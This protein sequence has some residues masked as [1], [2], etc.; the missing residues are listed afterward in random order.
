[1]KIEDLL[2]AQVRETNANR[3]S[4]TG[5]I[6]G[7]EVTWY[8]KPLCPKDFEIVSKRGHS[9]F[10]SNPTMG[11]MV[12]MLLHKIE[13]DSGTKVFSPNAHR[14]VMMRIGTSLVS[15]IFGALFGDD[16]DVETDDEFGE[17]LGNSETT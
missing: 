7:S 16:L 3:N 17:R 11:G 9:G 1:M 14:P 4:W 12:E 2:A 5:E 6:G 8:A 13:D 15:E 10:L